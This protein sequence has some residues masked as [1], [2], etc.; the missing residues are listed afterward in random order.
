MDIA[1]DVGIDVGMDIAIDVGMDIA[2]DVGIDVGMD[3]AIDIA[4]DVGI[5]VGMDIAIDV[6]IIDLV[7]CFVAVFIGLR[8]PLDIGASANGDGFADVDSPAP[9]VRLPRC[10][11]PRGRRACAERATCAERAAPATRGS[12][13]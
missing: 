13:A 12:P 3:I 8:S 5:D 2:I 4:I 6:G 1:I 11:G 10:C 7:S 9:G